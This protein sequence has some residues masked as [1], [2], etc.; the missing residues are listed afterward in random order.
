MTGIFSEM[1][2]LVSF[3]CGYRLPLKFSQFRPLQ[4]VNNWSLCRQRRYCSVDASMSLSRIVD[5]VRGAANRSLSSGDET[6][7]LW[8]AKKKRR[9]PN[10]SEADLADIQRA[11]RDVKVE[12]LGFDSSNFPPRNLLPS[13]DVM[14][15]PIS[16]VHVAES[17][18]LLMA[19]FIL[20]P[21]S[22]IPT[23]SHPS[24]F[25]FSKVL[26]GE[27]EVREY[28][29]L[30]EQDHS[31]TVQP[32]N[33]LRHPTTTSVAGDVRALTPSRG[34]IHSFHARSWTAVFDLLVPPYS[35]SSERTCRYFSVLDESNHV[36][37][38]STGSKPVK[39]KVRTDSRC[40][41]LALSTDLWNKHPTCSFYSL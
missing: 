38:G 35:P 17:D 19:V 14:R 13:T 3:A 34:N 27:L 32:L 5:V 26:F 40:A 16:Y 30:Q 8:F 12:D 36:Q 39:L 1:A 2:A 28:D 37:D 24:M 23:H 4:R 33:A 41:R 6:N 18:D 10:L 15:A 20:P 7:F 11:M 9:R 25:V 22:S 29:L 21:G 31:N